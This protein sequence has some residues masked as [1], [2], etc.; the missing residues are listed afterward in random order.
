[1][2]T[3]I[4]ISISIA[5]EGLNENCKKKDGCFPI[6]VFNLIAFII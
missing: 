3:G 4:A 2:T 5:G 6:V 1:M